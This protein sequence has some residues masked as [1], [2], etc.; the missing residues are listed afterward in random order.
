MRVE[1]TILFFFA[2]F[3]CYEASNFK[4]LKIYEPINYKKP[5]CFNLASASSAAAFSASFLLR[6]LPS[7]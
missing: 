3:Q 4:I 1:Y 5:C 7:P 6:P 2:L